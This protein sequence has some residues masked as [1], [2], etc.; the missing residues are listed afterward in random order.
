MEVRGG[1]GM[2]FFLICMKS[3]MFW[4]GFEVIIKLCMLICCWKVII[5]VFI[6]CGV[7]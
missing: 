1:Y 7:I 6:I 4:R 2:S 3:K 5:I